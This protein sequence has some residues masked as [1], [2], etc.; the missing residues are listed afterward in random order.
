[1][2]HRP[3]IPAEVNEQQRSEFSLLQQHTQYLRFLSHG[4]SSAQ[5]RS[6]SV[7]FLCSC[8]ANH[9]GGADTAHKGELWLWVLLAG[10]SP[11][12][13]AII[14]LITLTIPPWKPI[15]FSPMNSCSGAARHKTELPAALSPGIHRVALLFPLEAGEAHVCERWRGTSL[16]QT[17]ETFLLWQPIWR[18]CEALYLERETWVTQ[19][20]VCLG[21][22]MVIP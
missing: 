21:E 5:L 19:I 20:V 2:T 10:K 4:M 8:Q 6:E 22:G 13:E 3:Q 14:Y 9:L 11:I 15:Q 17:Q 18:R 16:C 7:A 1:M 12:E